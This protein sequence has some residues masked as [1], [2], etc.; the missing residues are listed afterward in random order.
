MTAPDDRSLHFRDLDRGLT[1][2]LFPQGGERV[3]TYLMCP[4]AW[5]QRLSGSEDLPKLI[6]L[7]VETGVPEKYFAKVKLAGPL[8][9]F[10]SDPRWVDHPYR[11]RVALIGDAAGATDPIW[12]QGVSLTLRDVRELRDQLTK[13]EDWDVAGQAYA[14]E[15]DRDYTVSRIAQSWN[16]RLLIET[17]PEADALRA[18]A[19]P[20]WRLDRSRLVDVLA[21]GPEESV[22]DARRRR[23]LG[24]E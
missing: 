19:F 4:T 12:G 14:S 24:E 21:S 16:D 22:E 11:D 18:Q 7:A 6:E 20:S 5:G 1:T 8:A 17:G 2:L 15:H 23:Y 9:T 13:H 3:R 10:E